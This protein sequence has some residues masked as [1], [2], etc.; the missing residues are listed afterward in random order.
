[1]GENGRGSLESREK[2]RP[3]S[4]QTVFLAEVADGLR[5]LIDLT[6]L[7]IPVGRTPFVPLTATTTLRELTLTPPWFSVKIIN[8]GPQTVLVKVNDE[9]DNA[10]P[11]NNGEDLN[12]DFGSPR[13]A[14]LLFQTEAATAALRL[15]GLY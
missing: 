1:M 4:L 15:I 14:L 7:Q 6:E 5:Q 8:D 11:I 9:H 13:V 3:D 12:L 2:V 10:I